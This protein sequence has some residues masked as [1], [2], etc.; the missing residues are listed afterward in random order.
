MDGRTLSEL[1]E[2]DYKTIQKHINNIYKSEEV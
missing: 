1:F 2:K